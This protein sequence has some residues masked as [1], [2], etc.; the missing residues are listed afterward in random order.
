M[1][2]PLPQAYLRRLLRAINEFGLIQSGDKILIGLSGGKDSVFLTYALSCLRDVSPRPFSLGA[3]TLDPLFTDN[4]DSAPLADFCASLDIPFATA[5]ADIA[6]TIRKNAS[7]DPCFTCAFFRRGAV[8]RY[9]Q[10]HGYDKV[11]LAHHH[12]DAVET[13]LMGILYSGQL[14]T[15]LP[16]TFLDRTGLTVIRPLIYFREQELRDAVRLH[17]FKPIPSPCPFNGKTKRQEVKDLITSLASAIP[18]IYDHLSSAM[19][20]KNKAELWPQAPDREEL[21]RRN[22]EFWQS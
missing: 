4:F 19:R 3:F 18:G 12:D 15:F 13:F 22:K 8:N 14:Q 10:T 9:A 6:G 7:K 5:K 16:S 17:E 1:K 2:Q 21:W 11:A 20:G